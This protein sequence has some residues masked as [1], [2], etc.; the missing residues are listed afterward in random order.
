MAVANALDA[1]DRVDGVACGGGPWRRP[2]GAVAV[3]DERTAGP[4]VGALLG[5]A[6]RLLPLQPSAGVDLPG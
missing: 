5:A 1:I 2:P 4:L 6:G 3:G